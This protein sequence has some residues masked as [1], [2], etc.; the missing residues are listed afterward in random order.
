MHE[1]E[2]ER[3]FDS[4]KQNSPVDL[5]DCPFNPEEFFYWED[6]FK[7]EE[8][9]LK[10]L[11]GPVRFY[12]G[13]DPATGQSIDRGDYSAII[14]VARDSDTGII[15][16]LDADVSKMLPESLVETILTYCQMRRYTKFG[17]EDNGFQELI[18]RELERRAAKKNIHAPV[19]GVKNTSDKVS[20]ILSLQ[21]MIK[22]GFLR[23]S[24][25]HNH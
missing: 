14:T 18:K 7:S 21:P 1:Q 10:T 22:S 16:V 20:R 17:I 19:Q 8:E 3:S 6:Q 25:R 13:C 24:R 5:K 2:G 23:F 4:E 9:L 11:K 12:A 15:Y